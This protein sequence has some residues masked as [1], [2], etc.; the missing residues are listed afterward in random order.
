MA[1]L[2]DDGSEDDFYVSNK[3]LYIEYK[4]WY[5][6]KEFALANG[7]P[8]PQIPPFIVDAMM[9]IATRLSYKPNFIRYSFREDMIG[10]G[11]V[12]CIRFADKFKL[13]YISKKDNQEKIGNP[14]SYITTTCFNAYLRRID[15]EKQ[16]KYV[17]AMIVA[18]SPDHEF[19]HQ[20]NDD[21]NSYVNQYVEFL[22]EAGCSD[23]SVPMSI[24]RTKKYQK[25]QD[26]K[27][28]LDEFENV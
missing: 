6:Q 4:E 22:R 10:D 23:D 8:D 28:P 9:K 12:D 5:A 3:Q 26:A 16:Q 25:T 24:K 19:L 17:K 21:D 1:D 27:G 2:I 7:L 14:F 20:S 11:L 13:T 15:K 18:Q